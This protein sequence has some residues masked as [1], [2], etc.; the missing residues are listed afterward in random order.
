MQIRLQI[1][2]V[3]W[4]HTEQFEWPMLLG[5]QVLAFLSAHLNAEIGI[6]ILC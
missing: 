1:I 6:L 4:R 2:A 3:V 5:S